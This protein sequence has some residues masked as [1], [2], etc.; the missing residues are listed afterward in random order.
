MLLLRPRI[1][2]VQR[3]LPVLCATFAFSLPPTT[4]VAIKEYRTPHHSSSSILLPPLP[5]PLPHLAVPRPASFV[6]LSRSDA[7]LSELLLT[8]DIELTIFL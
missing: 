4:T 8:T 3:P 6:S 7:K 5:P 2:L 1:A